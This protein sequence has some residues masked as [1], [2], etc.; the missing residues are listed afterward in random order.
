MLDAPCA[1]YARVF[2]KDYRPAEQ[3]RVT[4]RLVR[5]DATPNDSA[6]R[7][8]I[9]DGVPGRPGEYRGMLSNDAAGPFELRLEDPAGWLAYEVSPPPPYELEPGGMAEEALREAARLS[10]GR[11]YR[12]E[13]L[14]ALPDHVAPRSAEF[15][16]RAERL[17]WNPLAM[18]LFVGLVTT[19]WV[20]RKT[21]NLI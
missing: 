5:A 2:D 16:L 21:S 7:E 3:R 11:F 1:V 14:F 12:E 17:L 20:L 10:G 19:E 8:V 13:D 9:L 15:T 6:A 4:A 18:I